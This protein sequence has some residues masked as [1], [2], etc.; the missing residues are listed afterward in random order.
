[1]RLDRP[2]LF[3]CSSIGG[4][5]GLKQRGFLGGEGGQLVS[6]AGFPLSCD[7]A[8]EII[9]RLQVVSTIDQIPQALG[10]SVLSGAELR[11]Y[12]IRE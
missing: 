1:M 10:F 4:A 3:T 9:G 8:G 2:Y 6:V 7:R 12:S 11:V 5:E